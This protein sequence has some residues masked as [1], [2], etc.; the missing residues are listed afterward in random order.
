MVASRA[1][2]IAS[3][4]LIYSAALSSALALPDRATVEVAIAPLFFEGL[5]ATAFLSERQEEHELSKRQYAGGSE[6]P[7]WYTG[8]T[9][10]WASFRS[11]SW[12]PF[13]NWGWTDHTLGYVK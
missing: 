13:I 12:T 5:N 6:T 4:A 2:T 1:I 11:F 10:P 9:D 3:A 8:R 7:L